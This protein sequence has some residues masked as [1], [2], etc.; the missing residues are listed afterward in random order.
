MKFM[1]FMLVIL[2]SSVAARDL[3]NVRGYRTRTT[4]LPI[5]Y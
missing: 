2:L 3:L 4:A 1:K 5:I